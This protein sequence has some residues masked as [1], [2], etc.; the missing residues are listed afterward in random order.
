MDGV[1]FPDPF[2]AATGRTPYPWQ[3][4]L[5]ARPEPTAA[6]VAPT[7]AGKTEAI[8]L[9]WQWRG[10]A[11]RAAGAGRDAPGAS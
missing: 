5:A 10:R 3:Q 9:D 11:S 1:V 2:R 6:L 8:L 4:A 7:G